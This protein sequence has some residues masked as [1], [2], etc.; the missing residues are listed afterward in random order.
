MIKTPQKVNKTPQKVVTHSRG[1]NRIECPNFREGVDLELS[2]L[3]I[4]GGV[5]LVSCEPDFY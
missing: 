4:R 1:W 3:I 2:V 5:D